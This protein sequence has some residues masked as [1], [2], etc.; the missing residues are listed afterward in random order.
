[1]SHF[2]IMKKNTCLFILMVS[3]AACGPTLQV[4]YDQDKSIKIS[5]YKTFGWLD[6]KG[7]EGKNT[8][9]R[10]YNELTD[11]RIKIAVD[12]EMTAKGFSTMHTGAQLEMHY[13]IIVENK[14]GI[15]SEPTNLINGDY[16]IKKQASTYQYREGTLIIDI[17]D[18]KTNQLVWRGS[19]TDVI[20][21]EITKDP[22]VAINKTVK[23]ILKKF[24]NRS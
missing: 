14:T 22:E 10:Y 5:N 21:V 1:M 19:G 16:W 11:K 6:V 17:M 2:C 20:T 13:H 4:S 23:E 12:R 24:P 18:V 9:P 3:L 8:D 7:I 15:I